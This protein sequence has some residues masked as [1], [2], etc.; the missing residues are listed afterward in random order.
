M[1][2][3]PRLRDD[4]T[5]AE[6]FKDGESLR[7]PASTKIYAGAKLLRQDMLHVENNVMVDDF[8]LI[9]APAI[10]YRH[11]HIAAF[12]SVLGRARLVMLPFSGLSTGVRVFTSNDD[13][14]FGA[15]T[16]PTVPETARNMHTEPVTIGRHCI[17]GANSVV[18]PG[19]SMPEGSV[20]GANGLLKST[21]KLE[22]WAIYAGC[23]ARKI[24][25]RD[26]AA[27]INREKQL[28]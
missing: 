26:G 24:G 25:E 23:P 7:L 4:G 19:V 6:I 28:T 20:L 5:I 14:R 17:V 16:N 9:G 13:Y 15:L 10:L 3:E 18:L 2:P 8:V 1:N 22:K 27:V 11:V 21:T 12:T